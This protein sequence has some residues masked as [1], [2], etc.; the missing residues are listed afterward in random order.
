MRDWGFAGVDRHPAADRFMAFVDRAES[1]CWWWKGCKRAGYGAFEVDGRLEPAHRASLIV[2]RG[3]D[4][5]RGRDKH[6]DHVCRNALCVNPDHLELVTAD[7]NMR[8]SRIA[9]W[10]SSRKTHCSKGHP[11]SGN[12]LRVVV[13]RGQTQHHCKTCQAAWASAYRKRRKEVAHGLA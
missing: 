2:L 5:P 10:G 6:V 8:R 3:M 9:R 13:W 4:L 11:M 12:N 1:G 7:E